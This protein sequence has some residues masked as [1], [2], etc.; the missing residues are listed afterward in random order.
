MEGRARERV[1]IVMPALAE[2][3]QSDDPFVP[4]GISGIKRTFAEGMA[5]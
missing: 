5:N 4:A 2:S 3:E 1:V